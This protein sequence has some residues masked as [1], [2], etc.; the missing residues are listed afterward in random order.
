MLVGGRHGIELPL[1]KR[2]HQANHR[3]SAY[4]SAAHQSDL[5]LKKSAH[6]PQKPHRPT[7]TNVTMRCSR[8]QNQGRDTTPRPPSTTRGRSLPSSH[9]PARV[10]STVDLARSARRFDLLL[11]LA[12]SSF[13]DLP[14]IWSA[15]PGLRTRVRSGGPGLRYEGA[16]SPGARFFIA[17]SVCGMGATGERGSAPAMH[18]ASFSACGASPRHGGD[19]NQHLLPSLRCCRRTRHHDAAQDGRA[20]PRQAPGGHRGPRAG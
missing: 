15:Q 11:L 14:G 4:N 10:R 6:L 13:L 9:T 12:L 20:Q 16:D 5:I 2:T 1:V 3:I 7:T 17:C 8:K 19:S 18:R